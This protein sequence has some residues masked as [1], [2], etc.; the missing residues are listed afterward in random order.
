MHKVSGA[1]ITEKE[2]GLNEATKGLVKLDLRD[3]ELKDMEVAR[4]L[5][6]EEVKVGEG[7]IGHRNDEH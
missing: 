6:D 3:Q 5:Q 4:K 2:Y 7:T 1:V